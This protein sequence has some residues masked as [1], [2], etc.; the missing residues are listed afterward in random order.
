MTSRVSLINKYEGT[1]ELIIHP[2]LATPELIDE[3]I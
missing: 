3:F 2:P 1:H